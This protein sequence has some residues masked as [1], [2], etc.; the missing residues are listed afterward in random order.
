MMFP[1]VLDIKLGCSDGRKG[2]DCTHKVAVFG[3]RVNYY[4]NGVPSV[5][6]RQFCDEINTYCVPRCVGDQEQM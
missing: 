1:Y 5:E 2:G 4:H 6:F 3:D